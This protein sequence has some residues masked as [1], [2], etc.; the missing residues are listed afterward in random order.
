MNFRSFLLLLLLVSSFLTVQGHPT[1]NSGDCQAPGDLF[2]V[3]SGTSA[4]L[5]WGAVTGSS[6][7]TVEVES[8]GAT[9]FFQIEVSAASNS[10]TVTGLVANGSYKFK[11]RT[12]CGSDKS[13]WSEWYNFSTGS[14]GGG[15]GGGGGSC[16]VPAGLTVSNNAGGSAT[17]SWDVVS[18]ATSY[19]VE[20]ESENFTPVFNIEVPVATNSYVVTGLTA[21]VTYKFKVRS[22]CGGGQSD[23]SGWVFFVSGGS[24]GGGSG[25]CAV[26]T[27]LTVSNNAG[28][29]A[30][31]SWGAVSGA[32]G[33]WV[34]VESENFTPVFNIEVPV[35]TNSYTVTGLTA[36]VTYKFK[37]RS[38][39]G[40]GQS[41]WSGWVFFVSGGSNGGGGNGSCTAPNTIVI[42]N[43]TGTSATINWNVV[44][45]A[46]AYKLEIENGSGN[47]NIFKDTATV[48]TN[49][50]TVNNL[51]P[52]LNYKVKVRTVCANGN[53]SNWTNW[54][55]FNSSTGQI[56]MHTSSGGCGKPNGLQANN[57]T[58]TSA[59]LSWDKVQNAVGYTVRVEKES[60]ANQEFTVSTTDTFV[61]VTGLVPGSLYKFKVRSVCTGHS[62]WSKW[63]FF[64]TPLVIEPGIFNKQ[65]VSTGIVPT[66]LMAYPN[67]VSDL[68]TVQ[69]EDVT[70]GQ[71]N[72]FIISDLSGRVMLEESVNAD[73]GN[74]TRVFDMSRFDNGVYL[75]RWSN[76]SQSVARKIIV[77]K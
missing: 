49:T 1:F 39:C 70:A 55:T 54:L 69:L 57:I 11:V 41:D 36:N 59:V 23:W 25:S 56:V 24:N 73:T 32:T 51:L 76:G 12:K 7:Y 68:L 64:S 63:K 45:G 60:G 30:T 3:V 53:H 2:A 21:N 31:L 66:A 74:L 13:D 62:K 34:E 58:N 71:K 38:V 10:Y 47:A 14:G 48:T 42:T 15:S 26:P 16:A 40:G 50:Y 35:A 75:L 5:S 22:V 27:G 28:G 20:V 61:M 44:A 19:W 67:P 43:A 4:D 52:G 72:Y 65:V 9:P 8:E 29:S 6:G 33:Y 46:I 37:V 77:N 17:L 18:G